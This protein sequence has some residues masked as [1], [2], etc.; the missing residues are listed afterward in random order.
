MNIN[1]DL[2]YIP[3]TITVHLG[4]PNE[5]AENVT[6]P[7]TDYI[8]NV[9]S[10]EIYPTWPEAALR[11]NILAQISFALNRVYTEYYRSRG[12]DFNITNSTAYDQAFVKGRSIFENVSKIVDEIFNEYIR[13]QGFVEPLLAHYC[14]GVQVSCDGLSQWGSVALANAG[15]KPFEILTNYYGDNIDL[16]M[17]DDIRSITDSYPAIPLK[18]GSV[19]NNVKMLQ[20]RLNRISRNYPSIPKI[21]PVNGAF[22]YGT[23]DA[24]RRFQEIFGLTPDAI[25]GKSTW[26]KIQYVFNGIKRLNELDS[27]GLTLDEISKQYA[28]MLERGDTG[29]EVK[30]L[31]YYLNYLSAYE[32]SIFELAVDGI[33]GEQTENAVLA[34]QRT[35]GLEPTGTVDELTWNTLYDAY[36]GIIS[37]LPVDYFSGDIIPYGGVVLSLGANVPNVRV[38]QEYLNYIGGT[39]GEIPPVEATGFF[40]PQTRDAVTAFQTRFGLEPTGTVGPVTWGSITD[41]YSDLYYGSELEEGQFPGADMGMEE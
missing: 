15:Y 12:Y 3:E 23:E 4:A 36:L 17:T 18:L 20:I 11:A 34:F 22:S 27:E 16:A 2:P 7:F 40:G 41:I 26:Y 32:E 9:A 35:Y 13:R 8:K 38:L 10:S 1:A 39:F 37:S 19:G 5:D 33:F 14:D 30:A 28:D 21:D 31:Q 29:N 6:V 24:V 25:V